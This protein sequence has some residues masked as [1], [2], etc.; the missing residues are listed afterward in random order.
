MSTGISNYEPYK[1]VTDLHI[2]GEDYM[3]NPAFLKSLP[4]MKKKKIPQES[5]SESH[6]LLDDLYDSNSN[7]KDA[8]SDDSSGKDLWLRKR[9]DK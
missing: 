1:R 2:P 6:E 3:H 9:L 7:R 4:K 5:G 8:L